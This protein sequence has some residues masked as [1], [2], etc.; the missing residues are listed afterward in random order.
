MGLALWGGNEGGARV[1]SFQGLPWRRFMS[2]GRK[3]KK[4]GR[5]WCLPRVCDPLLIQPTAGRELDLAS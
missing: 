1:R 2:L 3:E 4:R 5:D